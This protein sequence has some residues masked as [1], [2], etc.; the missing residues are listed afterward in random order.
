M[1][2]RMRWELFAFGALCAGLI[3]VLYMAANR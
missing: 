1:T 2:V 3:A